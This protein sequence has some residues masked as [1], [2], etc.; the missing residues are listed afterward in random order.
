VVR[1]QSLHAK[2][3]SKAL[4]VYNVNDAFAGIKILDRSR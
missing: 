4:N 1:S 2:F 3:S